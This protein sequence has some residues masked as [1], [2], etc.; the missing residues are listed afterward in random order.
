MVYRACRTCIEKTLRAGSIHRAKT[1]VKTTL[2]VISSFKMDE[3][4]H[5]KGTRIE[6]SKHLIRFCENTS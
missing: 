4:T 2:M 3:N 5:E 1:V 6:A